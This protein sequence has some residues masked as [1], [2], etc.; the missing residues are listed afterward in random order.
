MAKIKLYVKKIKELLTSR[1]EILGLTVA[2]IFVLICLIMGVSTLLDAESP[3]AKIMKDAERIKSA[4]TSSPRP[5]A[6]TGVEKKTKAREW[7]WP[8]VTGKDVLM[9]LLAPFQQGAAGSNLRVNPVI[10]AIDGDAGALQIDYLL[11]GIHTYDFPSSKP[12][13]SVFTGEK[14]EPVVVVDGKRLVVVTGTFPYEAQVEEYAKALR[15]DKTVDV[16][17]KQFAPIF[18]GLDVERRKITKK[19]GEDVIGDWVPLYFLRR[20]QGYSRH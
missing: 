18:E 4:R 19:G 5:P 2:G 7:E 8:K 1:M 12:N 13:L 9:T 16:F 6:K 17:A 15:L 3:E 11:H 14:K 10:L 20:R